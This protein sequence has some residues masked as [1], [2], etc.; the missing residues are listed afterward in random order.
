MIDLSSVRPQ[1]GLLGELLKWFRQ[2]KQIP[3]QESL[4]HSQQKVR[5]ADP[6]YFLPPEPSPAVTAVEKWEELRGPLLAGSPKAGRQLQS[7]SHLTLLDGQKEPS[8]SKDECINCIWSVYIE[9]KMGLF[10][11]GPS[12]VS[13]PVLGNL[14]FLFVASFLLTPLFAASSTS[15]APLLATTSWPRKEN[16]LFF[17]C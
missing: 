4:G 3:A 17:T 12:S 2:S 11:D 5:I 7:I 9:V 16:Y 13:S 6:F 8:L 14:T 1:S 15:L 10:I